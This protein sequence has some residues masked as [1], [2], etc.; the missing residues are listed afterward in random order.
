MT[1]NL[2]LAHASFPL[3]LAIAV[4]PMGQSFTLGGAS[5]YFFRI[6]LLAGFV[7][8]LLS[9]ELRALRLNAID[10]TFIGWAV[11]TVTLGSLSSPSWD[12]FV[13]RAGI[14]FNALTCYFFLRCVMKSIEDITW[15][16]RVLGV[17]AILV[18]CLMSYEQIT[19]KNL[20]AALGGVPEFTSIR[21]DSLR[22]Q[23]AFRHPILAA[24]FGATLIPLFV[25][26]LLYRREYRLIAALGILSSLVIVLT[27]SSGG[28]I[29]TVAAGLFG[30][31]LWLVRYN[32]RAVQI[33]AV[34]LIAILSLSMTAPVWY[35]LARVSALV[36]G[37]G[38]HRAYLIDVAVHN[39]DEWWQ[40][41]TTYT[42]HWAYAG[43]VILADPDMID[44]TNHYIMEGVKGG[45]LKLGLFVMLILFCFKTIGSTVT[46][47]DRSGPH[48]YLVW[49]L[50]VAMFA[51]CISFLGANYF[52][53][54][55]LMWFWLV[56]AIA[57]L[58]QPSV[59]RFGQT[60]PH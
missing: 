41:G 46:G 9:G 40:F 5:F 59:S 54:L 29:L 22:A 27:A 47:G 50:G 6:I 2:R 15:N 31:G 33:A 10:K 17:V 38:W 32:M 30:W 28:A 39:F 44:I 60:V 25:G 11:V 55:I 3:L 57:V 1:F 37:T 35:I 42:A 49:G 43:L 7:R 16:I 20:L 45:I 8:V 4:I 21:G 23:G 12:L 14:T 56:A 58:K 18:A 48:L 51:H 19:G 52:D 34:I 26:L 36:G 53:Q 13:N 24:A